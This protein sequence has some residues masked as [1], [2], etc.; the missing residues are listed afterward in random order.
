MLNELEKVRLKAYENAL[1]YKIY[2]PRTKMYHAKNMV[3]I[4]FYLV[5]KILFFNSQLEKNSG[6]LKSKWFG[7]S[8]V[9]KAFSHGHV[10]LHESRS[11]TTSSSK[12]NP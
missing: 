1:I 4:N 12:A 10:E 6:K 11:S 9:K 3:K 2:K 7:S 5:R 8:V